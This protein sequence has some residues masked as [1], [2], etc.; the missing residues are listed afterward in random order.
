ML[1]NN[2][3]NLYGGDHKGTITIVAALFDSG[4]NLTGI[5]YEFGRML[6]CGIKM[7]GIVVTVI[8]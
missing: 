8:Y 3:D 1:H 6:F 2:H 5:T 4:L 7:L